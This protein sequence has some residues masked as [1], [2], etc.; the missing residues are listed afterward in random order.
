MKIFSHPLAALPT[1]D[2][3]MPLR[4]LVIA[5][6]FLTVGAWAAPRP[7]APPWPEGGVLLHESFDQPCHIGADQSIDPAVWAE[8]WSG[9]ALNRS[10]QQSLVAPWIVPMLATNGSSNI[11]PQRG[12]LRF[13]YQPDSGLGNGT[14]ATLLTLVSTDPATAGAAW[15]TLVVSADGQSVL[16]TAEG[17]NGPSTCLTAPVTFQSSTCYL[18]TLAYTETNSTLFVNDQQVATGFGLP[19]V[20]VQVAPLTALVLGSR[21][22]GDQVACGQIDEFTALTSRPRLR[23]GPVF[24]PNCYV[25]QYYAVYSA[26]AALGSISDV[27]I[28][29]RL[30]ARQAQRSAMRM[31][32][33]G[34]T[35]GIGPMDAGT[36]CVTGGQVYMTNVVCTLDTNAGWTLSFSIAGGTNDIPYDIFMTP[37]LGVGSVTNWSWAYLGQGYTCNSYTFTNQPDQTAFYMLGDST[38]DSDGDGLGTAF[39]L[40]ISHSDPN[41]KFSRGDGIDDKT[42]WLQGRNPKVPGSF[43]DTNGVINLQVFTPLYR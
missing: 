20:P 1:S 6:L 17:A 2:S 21:L 13:W 26:E 37:S 43:P 27:E 7:A 10:S 8:S 19:N 39:E 36:G 9:Y 35:G 4:V 5:S 34:I 16:L 25:G 29:M 31:S 3:P 23:R 38:V 30:S 14:P 41:N 22:S 15:W 11:D 33:L 12:A 28:A 32:T 24:D 18:V 40:L 42:A